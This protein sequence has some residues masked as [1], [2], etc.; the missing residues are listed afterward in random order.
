MIA[1]LLSDPKIVGSFS[2]GLA[3]VVLN[4]AVLWNMYQWYLHRPPQ[5]ES[6]GLLETA[7][8][9]AGIYFFIRTFALRLFLLVL[10]ILSLGFF[11]TE[12]IARF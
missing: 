1:E 7:G 5:E 3:L 4:G 6:G 2:I 9:Y 12:L 11:V 10:G 8:R